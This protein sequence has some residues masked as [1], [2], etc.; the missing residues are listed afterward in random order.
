M[1]ASVGSADVGSTD[2]DKEPPISPKN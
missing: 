1:V 2:K